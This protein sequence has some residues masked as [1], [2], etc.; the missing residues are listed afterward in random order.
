MGPLGESPDSRI[1]LSLSL[2]PVQLPVV[3]AHVSPSTHVPHLPKNSCQLKPSSSV[4]DV[5]DEAGRC[6]AG[7]L[8]LLLLDED[9]DGGDDGGESGAAGFGSADS[10][11]EA[12]RRVVNRQGWVET[13][14]L[15]GATMTQLGKDRNLADARRSSAAEEHGEDAVH[16]MA[17]SGDE[18]RV[19][20]MYGGMCESLH[21]RSCSHRHGELR[22]RHND[23]GN[24]H[25]CHACIA[26]VE[27]ACTPRGG[28]A[29]MHA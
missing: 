26:A 7:T 15:G 29:A 13:I 6:F 28:N 8:L 23:G 12:R 9:D 19:A 17:W 11:V 4:V 16:S 14:P 5:S 20:Q 10:P 18:G 24:L 21:T 25:C 2:S 27:G 3:R 1:C 22:P